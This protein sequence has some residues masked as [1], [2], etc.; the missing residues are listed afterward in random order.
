MAVKTESGAIFR[1]VVDEQ[2]WISIDRSGHYGDRRLS[3]AEAVELAAEIL[4]AVERSRDRDQRS[5]P[6]YYSSEAI[7]RRQESRLGQAQAAVRRVF[8]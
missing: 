1:A 2:G 3:Q 4:D 7:L 6:S 8:K 5:E